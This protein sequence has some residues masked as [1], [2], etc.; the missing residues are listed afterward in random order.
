MT[1]VVLPHATLFAGLVAT[2]EVAVGTCLI[3]GLGTRIAAPIGA[4]LTLNYFLLKGGALWSVSNDVAFVV[5]L[6]GLAIT[7]GGRAFSLAALI[8]PRHSMEQSTQRDEGR[9]GGR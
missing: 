3:L 6:L 4:F 9:I 7:G 5:G 8:A 2:G 1:S